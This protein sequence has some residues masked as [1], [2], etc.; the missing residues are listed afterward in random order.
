MYKVLLWGTGRI[1]AQCEKNGMNAEIIGYVETQKT[2]EWYRGIVK[3]TI[4][5][6]NW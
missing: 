6:W 2:E 4:S 3:N 5:I 1:S